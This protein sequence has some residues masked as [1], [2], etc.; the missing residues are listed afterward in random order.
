VW[1]ADALGAVLHDWITD[2]VLGQAR[3]S[4]FLTTNDSVAG[5]RNGLRRDFRQF[6]TNRLKRSSLANLYGRVHAVLGGDARFRLLVPSRDK[7]AQVWGLARWESMRE[8]TGVSPVALRL[9]AF[10]VTD[11]KEV[12]YRADAAK[13]APVLEGPDLP[14]FLAEVLERLGQ[15]L[16]LDELLEALATRFNLRAP[17]EV[18]FEGVIDDSEGEARPLPPS[19]R[20]S[21]DQ[22]GYADGLVLDEAARAAI[23][24]LSERK[25]RI[26]LERTRPGATYT[27]IAEAVHCGKSTVATELEA[28]IRLVSRH[29]QAI[30]LDYDV[31]NDR[32]LDHLADV[33]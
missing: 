4:Y 32:I 29:A 25:R 28:A 7:G 19:E 5:F 9:A 27:S 17:E 21:R 11:I 15:P 14:R 8:R 31:L 16:N 20:L 6:M 3:L 13:L 30:G 33:A 18:P 12:T 22:G 2:R 23:D 24:D 26:L 1:D 10:E